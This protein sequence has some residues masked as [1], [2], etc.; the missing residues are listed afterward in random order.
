[1]WWLWYGSEA[2]SVLAEILIIKVLGIISTSNT[3][4]QLSENIDIMF[5]AWVKPCTL[6]KVTLKIVKA[7][8]SFPKTI[9]VISDFIAGLSNWRIWMYI[10]RTVYRKHLKTKSTYVLYQ[11]AWATVSNFIN[12]VWIICSVWVQN[13]AGRLTIREEIRWGLA[14]SMSEISPSLPDC[15]MWSPRRTENEEHAHFLIHVRFP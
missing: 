8:I 12:S 11:F 2:G 6:P 5:L 1:M 15:M 3:H 10:W 4:A 13:E 9:M 14:S 7:D